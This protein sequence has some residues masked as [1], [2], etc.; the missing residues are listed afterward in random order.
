[1]NN[2]YLSK[3]SIIFANLFFPHI[4][5]SDTSDYYEPHSSQSIHEEYTDMKPS[6]QTFM[7]PGDTRTVPRRLYKEDVNSDS[8]YR[9]WATLKHSAV[10]RC[11]SDIQLQLH[12]VESDSITCE[13]QQEQ[14]E[15]EQLTDKQEDQSSDLVQ[16]MQETQI[17]V[18][19]SSHTENVEQENFQQ[20]LLTDIPRS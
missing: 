6:L 11:T 20:E 10:D 18:Q 4:S 17:P 8:D 12:N 16:P 7:S 13:L 9:Q 5:V 1:M 3:R 14:T 2:I 15:T 19:N